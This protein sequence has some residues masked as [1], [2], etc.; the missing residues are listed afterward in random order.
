MSCLNEFPKEPPDEAKNYRYQNIFY[1]NEDCNFVSGM[2]LSWDS[3]SGCW[4]EEY[5][6][7][8]K[9]LTEYTR[10]F[11]EKGKVFTYKYKDSKCSKIKEVLIDFNHCRKALNSD[12]F[13]Y[14]KATCSHIEIEKDAE[15]T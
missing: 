6:K 2:G 9:T 8:G 10:N 14:Q 5:I 7:D 12:I 3:I 1:S 4:K 11:C 13:S 15:I